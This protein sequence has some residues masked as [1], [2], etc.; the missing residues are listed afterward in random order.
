M[1][2]QLF[3]DLHIEFEDFEAHCD[4]ADVVVF[5]G[6]IHIGVKGIE[7]IERQNINCPIIYVL[8]NHEY[9]RHKYPSLIRK[10]KARVAGTNI[11][12]L[13]NESVDI[14]GV[15][16]H[17]ATLWTNFELYGNPKVAGY[18]CQQVMTDFK[19]IRKEP[20]YSKLR[21]LDVAIIHAHSMHWL[22]QSLNDSP[23]ALNVVVT[24]HAPS[25]KSVPQRY[26]ENI[27]TAAYASNL[28]SFIEEFKPDLWLHG[29]LHNSSN[30]YVG[31]C[32]IRCNPRGY[33]DERNAEFDPRLLISL[34]ST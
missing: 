18:E 28:E 27:V 29:H 33:V 25:I 12:V 30:Y 15:R 34:P 23:A 26:K 10:V 31:C 5:A 17:G 11:H 3:S 22:S 6:D 21:S 19:K 14:N 8:G 20:S 1:N 16:F 2:I 9:Y 13:E 7:W 4:G 32:N 24:H